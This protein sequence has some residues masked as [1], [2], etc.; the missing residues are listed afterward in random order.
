[1]RA[2]LFITSISVLL[3]SSCSSSEKA[4]TDEKI[5]LSFHPEKGLKKE[6]HYSM[7]V[8]SPSLNATLNYHMD[9]ALEVFET[10]DKETD[11]VFSF[12]E[13]TLDG[14]VDTLKIDLKASDPDSVQSDALLYAQPYFSC[15][16]QRFL[17]KYDRKM[18]RIG[19]ELLTEKDP[20]NLT[21]PTNKAQFFTTLPDAEIEVG[22]K[23]ESDVDLKAGK[24]MTVKAEFTV[25]KIEKDIVY[26]DFNGDLD[27]KGEGFGHDFSM[28]GKVTGTLE[29]DAQSGLTL[30]GEMI[31]DLIQVMSGKE[32]PMKMIIRID[33]K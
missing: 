3:F 30:K 12:S 10:N 18:T 33:S 29:V 25:K 26:I 19:E 21:D 4:E 23:W 7:S 2:F 17:V 11:L 28:K 6:M 31:Q 22:T 27:G 16:N 8:E 15:L 32:T 9:F 24:G 1:M 14:L 5:K 20:K 13:I